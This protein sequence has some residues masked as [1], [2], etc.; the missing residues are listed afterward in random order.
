MIPCVNCND[1]F[2]SNYKPND[3]IIA[4]EFCP[5][6]NRNLNLS[7]IM[8][9]HMSGVKSA[10]FLFCLIINRLYDTDIFDL[11]EFKDICNENDKTE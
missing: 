2:K 1:F 10:E 4:N 7:F 11:S 5:R 6:C 3:W 8:T 9:N